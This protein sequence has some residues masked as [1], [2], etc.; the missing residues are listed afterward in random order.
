MSYLNIPRFHF[1]GR[2]QADPS[3]VNNN[4]S[5][6][7]PTVELSDEP[8]DSTNSL[9]NTSV[10][11]NPNGTHNWQLLDCRVRGAA[12]SSGAFA[13]PGYDPIIGAEVRSAGAYPAKI[14][15]LDPDNQGV[16]QIWGLVLEVRIVDP[17]DPAKTL[18]SVSARMPPTAFCD[19]WNRGAGAAQPSSA[20]MSACFRAVLEVVRWENEAASPLLAAL[21]AASPTQLSLSFMVDSYQTDSNQEN[22]TQ[23]RVVGSFGPVLAG[24]APR[25]TPRRLSPAAGS[26]M[27]AYG[28]AGAAWDAARSVLVLDLG[29]CLPTNA[30][31]PAS[32]PS[33]PNAGWPINSRQLAL[34]IPGPS[35]TPPGAFTRLKSGGRA[36]ARDGAPVV[37]G[38]IAFTEATYLDF[39]GIVEV[40]LSAQL[41]E[42]LQGQPM[43]LTD[44]TA[45][46]VAVQEDAEGR[47]VDVDTP[48]CR[49]NPGE[50]ASIKLWATQ[51][52]KPWAGAV[53]PL[54]LAPPMNAANGPTVAPF[55]WQNG[56]PAAAL[57]LSEGSLTTGADGTATLTLTASDPGTPRKY[58]DQQLGPDGQVYWISGPWAA[59][60]KIFL[61]SGAPIN[62]LVFS[63]C[64]MPQEPP[65]WDE[66]VGP[67]LGNYARL[68]PYMK[69]IIDIG[70]YETVRQNAKAIHHVLNLP[71]ADPHHMP[72]VR[73]LSRSKLAVINRWFDK[74]ML[75]S[76]G[77]AEA[78]RVSKPKAQA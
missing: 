18:A 72:V 33:V 48:F 69:G 66:H 14:V 47:Y 59:W 31:P 22:F 24:E 64:V 1:A 40:P 44:T 7:D 62:V 74:G 6:Y 46:Q 45:G 4:D 39:A 58:P 19:L 3:T 20:T 67:I 77:S 38:T 76:S 34:T 70:D 8:P 53:L 15:D 56:T 60:G 30:A 54:G 28:A 2:F 26:I 43:T 25:S 73:D 16:S 10:Y 9:N 51:F 71:A 35:V 52:G 65:T 13:A 57:A 63:H 75:R 55:A 37:L 5:N 17:S 32:G 21:K 78:S 12:T 61:F 29:N 23:G 49:L 11:W 41:A 42:L 68:Y 36:G 50:A 27:S